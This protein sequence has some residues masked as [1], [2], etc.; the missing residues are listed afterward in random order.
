MT[1]HHTVSARRNP[2]L[3]PRRLLRSNAAHHPV[4]IAEAERRNRDFQVRLADRITA[5]AG[6]MN[7]VWFHAAIFAVWMLFLE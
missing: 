6:S 7:F 1:D 4:V 5:F 2:Q 3:V